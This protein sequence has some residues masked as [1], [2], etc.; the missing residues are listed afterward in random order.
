[1]KPLGV[2]T[3][4]DILKSMCAAAE[5][6]GGVPVPNAAAAA[7]AAAVNAEDDRL[8]ELLGWLPE[9]GSMPAA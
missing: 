4:T 2:I 6:Q 3:L 5:E 7:A 8:A 9:T 1:M